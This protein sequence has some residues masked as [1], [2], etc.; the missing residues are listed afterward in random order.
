MDKQVDMEFV[1]SEYFHLQ[2][3]VEDF[4][5]RALGIKG[6]S[7]T[8]SMAGLVAAFTEKEPL[9]LLLAAASAIM[10]WIIEAYWKRFQLAYFFRIRQIEA[11][12]KGDDVG[13]FTTPHITGSWGIGYSQYSILNIMWWTQVYLPHLVIAIAGFLLWI[14]NL[15]LP[16]IKP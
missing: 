13:T 1:R 9:I 8:V 10:F 7:V 11:Y 2:K 12:M 5:Q 14:I 4:D 15:F 3:T 6:W 16:I